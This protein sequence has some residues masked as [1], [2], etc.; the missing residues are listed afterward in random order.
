MRIHHLDC[1]TLCTAGGRFV[2]G[3]DH[4]GLVCHCLLLETEAGLV[5]VDSGLGT[6]DIA[7][8]ERLGRSFAALVR[9]KLDP[10]Q[11]A[12]AQIQRLGFSAAGVKHLV[13]THLD[14]DHAGGMADFPHAKIHVT[15]QEHE[16]AMLAAGFRGKRRYVS[17]QFAHWPDFELYMTRG[18]QWFGLEAIELRG[19]PDTLLVPLF[20]HT[21][22]HAGVAVRDGDRG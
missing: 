15:L 19:V 2:T 11:T 5:L 14:L 21:R 9:P 6:A 20:G 1:A 17:R 22:G 4:R 12:L 10:A 13:L 7:S 8:P 16:A 3:P 18:I